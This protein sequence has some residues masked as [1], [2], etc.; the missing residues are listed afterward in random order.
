LGTLTLSSPACRRRRRLPREEEAMAEPTVTVPTRVPARWANRLVG[1]SLKTP[2]L[3][4]WLGRQLG[5][6]TFT[7]HRSGRSFTTPTTYFRDGGAVLI[8]TKQGRNSWRNFP[9]LVTL[10]IAGKTITGYADAVTDDE[11]SSHW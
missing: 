3:Q 8:I 2:G 11:T 4:S 6:I 9:A 5:L 10:R 7:G 1:L